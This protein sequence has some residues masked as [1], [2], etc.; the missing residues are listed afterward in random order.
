MGGICVRFAPG[1]LNSPENTVY[2]LALIHITLVFKPK[3]VRTGLLRLHS[4]IL[5]VA[6]CMNVPTAGLAL[7]LREQDG[8]DG[9]R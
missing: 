1:R 9:R 6:R 8:T 2:P 5:L 7:A 3:A 4:R